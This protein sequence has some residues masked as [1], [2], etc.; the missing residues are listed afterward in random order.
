MNIN[1]EQSRNRS[2]NT[3]PL[4]IAVAIT[5]ASG[6]IYGI[7]LIRQLLNSGQQVSLLISSAGRQVLAVE[8]NLDW[9]ADETILEQQVQT[10][11]APQQD[12]NLLTLSQLGVI[13]L[14]AMPAFYS[15]PQSVEDMINFVVGKICDTLDLE[16]HLF[17][18]WGETQ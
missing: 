8:H 15:Q 17:Y 2:A 9:S 10:Y 1:T 18:R 14:P 12:Q 3:K 13:I 6:A 11:F 4:H 7:T 16:H 5:G